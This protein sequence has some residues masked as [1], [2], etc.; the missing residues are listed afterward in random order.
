[1]SAEET[2]SIVARVRQYI[3]QQIIPLEKEFLTRPFPELLPV[4][5][6]RRAQVKAMG[7][8][9]PQL[10][11]RWGG[12]GLRLPEFARVSEELGRTPLGHYVFNGQAPDAGNMEILIE[13]GSAEQ[14]AR[15]LEPLARGDCRSCFAMTEP[16]FAGSNPV[17]MHTRARQHGADYILDG[18][19][20]F[21]SAMDGAAFAIVMAVTDPD[22]AQPHRRASQIIVPVDTPGFRR[23]RNIP[24][25]GE[26]GADYFSHAEVIFQNCRVPQ[27]YRLGGEGE[28]FVIAQQRLGP[29][30]IHHGMRWIGICERAFEL[31]CRRAATRELAP[32]EPLASRQMFQ[33]RVADSRAEINAA[34]LLVLDAAEKIERAGSKAAREEISI[35]K[36]YVANVLQQVLDRALQAHGALGLTDD[37]VLAWWYRHERGARIY[38]G[39]DEVHKAVVARLNLK[40]HGFRQETGER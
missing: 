30:R 5:R 38:D 36:F 16:E 40:R 34:R 35:I 25:M 18:H 6:E 22:A 27:T 37:L 14:Q 10:P 26:P 39:P 32:G 29:G 33:E 21:T 12:L 13:H 1:M 19:K 20:W 4:L 2:S 31:M 23:V 15:W 24:L 8:W 28:G 3:E 7:L 11:T 17:W 9:A